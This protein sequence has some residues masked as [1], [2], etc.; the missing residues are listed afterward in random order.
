[1]KP[2]LIISIAV[3]IAFLP[4][5]FFMNNAFFSYEYNKQNIA[6]SS[7]FSL[8]DYLF[9]NSQVLGYFF[10]GAR[11]IVITDRNGKVLPYFFTSE[12]IIHMRDVKRLID[13]VA[14][15]VLLAGI[16]LFLFGRKSR[17]LLAAAKS[18]SVAVMVLY[19]AILTLVLFNFDK[20]FYKFHELLFTNSFWLLP[21]T[22]MLIRMYPENLFYDYAKLW[23]ATSFIISIA[24]LSIRKRT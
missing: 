5:A 24:V 2:I 17:S 9:Y 12:E 3:L 23:F 13:F 20:T 11:T 4:L 18:A 1:M 19:G 22:D 7:G 10:N 8:S 15:I 6:Y 16:I 21:E 14:L